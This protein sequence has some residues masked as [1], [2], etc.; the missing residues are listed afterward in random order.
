MR[1]VFLARQFVGCVAAAA[2]M[3]ASGWSP[4][5]IAQAP[6]T[7]V[8]S[9]E[10]FL[11]F[12]V[13]TDNKLARWDKIVDYMRLVANGSDRVRFRELGQSTSGNPFI[14][15]EISAPDTLNRLDHYKQ[16]ERRLYFQDGVPS[17]AERDEIFREG[18]VVVVVTCSIHATEIGATQMSMELVHRLATD[19]SPEVKKILDNVIFVLLPSVNPDGE[20]LVTDWFNRNVGTPYERSPIP[21]LYHPYVGHDNNRDLYMFTQKES[22]L[23]AQ[24]LWHDWFPVVWLDEHQMGGNA[25]RIF[26]MPAT[27]PINPNVHPLIY[28]WNGILGQSQAA[29]LEAAGK[30]GIIYNSTY[31]NFWE[32]AMAWSGWWHNEVGLL[33]EVAS[34][35]VAAPTDQQRAT[36]GQAT[37]PRGGRGRGRGV[38]ETGHA[39]LPPPNDIT[40]RT[41]YPRPWMGGHWTLRNIVDY[42][43]VATMGL[44]DTVADRRETLLRQIYEVNR[45]TVEN[46]RKGDPG[47][48]LIPVASQ[49]DPNEALH[50][51]EKLQMGGVEVDRA[52]KPFQAGGVSYAAGTFV[53]PMTQVF[54]RYAKDILE[55]Q[56]YPEVRRTP[57]SPPEPPYDVTAWSLGMLLGVDVAFVD[58]PLGSDVALRKLDA[59]PAPG[60]RV[61]GRGSAYVFDYRGP[62]A[63]KAINALLKRGAHVSIERVPTDEDESARVRVTGAPADALQA[64]ARDAG[65]VL[66]AASNAALAP[67]GTPLTAPRIGMYQPWTGGNMDEGWTRWVL[68]QYGFASTPLHNADIRAGGLRDRFDAIVLADQNP[69]QMIDGYTGPAIRPEYRGGLGDEGVAALKAFVGAGGT[70]V[71]LGAACDFAIDQFPLPVDDL[72]RGL[73]RDQHFAPGTILRVEVDPATAIGAGMPRSTYGFYDNSPFFSVSDGFASQRTTIVAR[74]P[75]SHLVASGWLKGEDLMAGRAAVVSVDLHPGRTV[76]FGLR[77][78]HRAQTHAT[79]PLLFNALYLSAAQR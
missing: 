74:Y 22:Q 41:E 59:A 42:E 37:A 40:P 2:L 30:D 71:T 20:I 46:G 10:Q 13:G 3:L 54:A 67:G 48:I 68:E 18:K 25:A 75:N 44:L 33:T 77:P 69:R 45:E 32:G 39:P 35:D 12:R 28:R 60:G 8:Q 11:G 15:L 29:A 27:D 65:L 21:Y 49:H 36:P 51:V 6:G 7:A 16:L 61:E 63:A 55:K 79:F 76:L 23:T 34:V 5:A 47:A 53:I 66:T 58:A 38:F 78:Q 19:P 70:L 57:A 9:P 1:R 26:V 72:Q 62:D 4:H 50:L 43:L 56:T 17:D 31:T 14:A 64:A 52:E 24:L 73:T